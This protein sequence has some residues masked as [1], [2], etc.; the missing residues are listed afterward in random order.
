MEAIFICG[1]LSYF[2]KKYMND[3]MVQ[4]EIEKHFPVSFLK[5]ANDGEFYNAYSYLLLA[6]KMLEKE[7]N[8]NK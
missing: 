6:E 1:G 8:I 5:I 7:S 4:A 3:P 2:F